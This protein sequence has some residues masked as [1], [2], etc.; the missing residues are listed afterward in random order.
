LVLDEYLEDGFFSRKLPIGAES[1]VIP[2]I[3]G[4]SRNETGKKTAHKRSLVFKPN[5]I[6]I[7]RCRSDS[8]NH[9]S[10]QASAPLFREA[11]LESGVRSQDR[12]SGLHSANDEDGMIVLKRFLESA[13]AHILD[14]LTSHALK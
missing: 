3:P 7:I 9:G 13:I 5:D 2:V 14:P 12:H 11:G 8:P 6:F 1:A 10:A 4:S